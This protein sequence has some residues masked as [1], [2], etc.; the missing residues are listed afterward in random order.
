MVWR[1]EQAAVKGC[2]EVIEN[3][4][5]KSGY[6]LQHLSRATTAGLGWFLDLWLPK[7]LEP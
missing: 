1:W 3:C 7:G 4:Q 5:N 6:Q 2:G